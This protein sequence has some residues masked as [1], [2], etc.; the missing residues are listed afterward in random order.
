MTFREHCYGL[1]QAY[2]LALV[3]DANLPL[4]KSHAVALKKVAGQ[5]AGHTV[6]VAPLISPLHYAVC[7]HEL[8]HLVA[9]A[10]QLGGER[11]A[12]RLLTEEYAAW[13]WAQATALQWTPA[14]E[15][16]KK[17][18]LATYERVVVPCPKC[19]KILRI[20]AVRLRGKCKGCGAKVKVR[21]VPLT[22]GGEA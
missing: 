1:A 6:F 18:A 11:T 19:Q 22:F 9:P 14:M 21:T 20:H 10:G 13:E 8:G 3:E 4:E 2:G 12:Q 15:A 17:E 16:L 5:K 7:L